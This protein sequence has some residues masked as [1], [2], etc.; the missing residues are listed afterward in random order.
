MILLEN[1]PQ[2]KEFYESLESKFLSAKEKQTSKDVTPLIRGENGV[3]RKIYAN[4]RNSLCKGIYDALTPEQKNEVNQKFNLTDFP[5]GRFGA[6]DDISGGK[7]KADIFN[8]YIEALLL[9]ADDSAKDKILQT[10]TSLKSAVIPHTVFDNAKQ[11]YQK[12]GVELIARLDDFDT[13]KDKKTIADDIKTAYEQILLFDDYSNQ[14]LD[15]VNGITTS[16]YRDRHS[17]MI[18]QATK[19]GD[20]N[21]HNPKD[22]NKLFSVKKT[23]QGERLAISPLISHDGK[24]QEIIDGDLKISPAAVKIYSQIFQKMEELGLIDNGELQGEQGFKKYAFTPLLDAF[25][26]VENSIK[27]PTAE[28]LDGLGELN[29]KYQEKLEKTRELY[30]FTKGLLDKTAVF[31]PDNVDTLRTVGLPTEF[32][33]DPLVNIYL[34]SAYITYKQLK[35]YGVS[36]EEFCKSPLEISKKHFDRK[37]NERAEEVISGAKTQTVDL[38]GEKVKVGR[39]IEGLILLS[40]PSFFLNENGIAEQV[41][42]NYMDTAMARANM[43]IQKTEQPN[44]TTPKPDFSFDSL[45]YFD[46]SDIDYSALNENIHTVLL[47]I[48]RQEQNSI[49]DGE[50]HGEDLA[51]TV[52]DLRNTIA[53]IYQIKRPSEKIAGVKDLYLFFNDPYKYLSKYADKDLKPFI[54]K[55]D[56]KHFNYPNLKNIKKNISAQ[57]KTFKNE[58]K[59]FL[60]QDKEFN[61][62]ADAYLKIINKSKDNQL[63]Q[64][65]KADYLALKETH[66]DILHANANSRIISDT[67]YNQRCNDI[68]SDNYKRK[69]SL[70]VDGLCDKKTYFKEQLAKGVD[71][72]TVKINYQKAVQEEK[73]GFARQS[74]REHHNLPVEIVKFSVQDLGRAQTAEPI[75]ESV[76]LSSIL[77]PVKDVQPTP[78]VQQIKETQKHKDEVSI[79]EE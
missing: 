5:A 20:L 10:V 9:V 47:D 35:T 30:G 2:L 45:A 72:K 55:Y 8:E 36:L 26:E 34:N 57:E 3:L 18:D 56:V 24:K 6:R 75:R 40:G 1:F 29:A 23:S 76:E 27:N 12:D 14:R 33:K 79:G 11:K 39:A 64:K 52:A 4:Q 37:A 54:P 31:A 43:P 73:S 65:A 15:Y 32:K 78:S 66:L 50:F 16:M 25:G 59:I 69:T 63:V 38:M 7:F 58:L 49:R 17:L 21:P 13:K 48:I 19:S 71:K 60:K 28:S 53:E 46:K 22:A 77:R 67:Y 41:F 70:Y 61:K 74:A 68:L 44:P 51:S 62:K 42:Q